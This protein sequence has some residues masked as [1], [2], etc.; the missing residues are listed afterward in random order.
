MAENRSFL[1]PVAFLADH[2]PAEP[3]ITWS[4]QPDADG[5]PTLS[6]AVGQA[7]GYASVCWVDGTRDLEFD[8]TKAMRCYDGL[9]AF[10]S[11]WGDEIR[12]QAN[13]AT[14]AK[15]AAAD[16]HAR[17][18]AGTYEGPKGEHSA[19]TLGEPCKVYP[20]LRHELADGTEWICGGCG[21]HNNGGI[22]THCGRRAY[23]LAAGKEEG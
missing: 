14:A 23:S 10:L 12:K 18:A 6:E 21:Y 11:D 13:E 9:M 17:L 7:L 2:R 19:C 15:L 4:P 1:A 3:D 5:N 8:S 20:G 16:H 22:C